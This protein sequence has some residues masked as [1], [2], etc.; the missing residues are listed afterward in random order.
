MSEQNDELM[1]R[2][3]LVALDASHHSLAALEAAVE[4]ASSLEAE[5]MGLFVEDVNL[6]RVAG[7][8]AAREVRFPFDAVAQLDRARMER[9][10]RAQATQARQALVAACEQRQVKWSF[11]VVRGEVTPEVL[12]A[13]LEADLLTLGRASRPLIRRVRLGST[14][15]A[16]A[17]LAPSS[18]LLLQ[19]DVG[20]KPPVVVTCDD[21]PTAQRALMLAIHLARKAGDY[22]TILILADALE[23]AR[24][25]QT[26]TTDRLREQGLM[27]RYRRLIDA[28]V[29]TLI[30][31]VR[32]EGSGVL[33]L[34]STILPTEA[35][36]TLLAEVDCPVLLVR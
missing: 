16:A 1:I 6:L 15:R 22:L 14:A 7:L 30:Y 36:Q 11:R 31:E 32:A 26:Q 19:R 12:A 24:R 10:L 21:S 33:V 34:S 28:G 20:I 29:A 27:V 23:K 4:L 13:A 35:L 25:L 5:L 17:A 8:S 2:R 3:I 9:E 18:V